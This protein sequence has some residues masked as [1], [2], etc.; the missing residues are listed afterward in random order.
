M[1]NSQSN[2]NVLER[3]SSAPEILDAEIVEMEAP[4]EG[5]V[6]GPV[7]E[8]SPEFSS[9]HLN[10]MKLFVANRMFNNVTFRQVLATI[11]LQC[12][13]Q[14]EKII[15]DAPNEHLTK[16]WSDMQQELAEQYEEQQAQE[17]QAQEQ[18]AE[19]KQSCSNPDCDQDPE[20]CDKPDCSSK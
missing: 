18:Q 19:E 3:E 9:D 14:A 6:E 2:T 15:N 8:G 12:R 1:D 4:V 10:D 20:T 16:I 5:P 11:D 17:Q 7:E 13:Q